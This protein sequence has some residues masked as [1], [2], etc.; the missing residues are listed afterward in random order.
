MTQTSNLLTVVAATCL[1]CLGCE[2][3]PNPAGPA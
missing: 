2:H 3:A 1:V